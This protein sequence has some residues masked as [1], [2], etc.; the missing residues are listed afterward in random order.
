M[1]K[2]SVAVAVSQITLDLVNYWCL[3]K[4]VLKKQHMILDV[5]LIFFLVLQSPT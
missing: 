5:R 4:R 1:W 3:A 2:S